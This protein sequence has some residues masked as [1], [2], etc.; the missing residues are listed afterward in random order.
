MYG[1]T[2]MTNLWVKEHK[3]NQVSHTL[4]YIKMNEFSQV[5]WYNSNQSSKKLG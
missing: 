3:M 2:I 4:K 1:E 5:Q